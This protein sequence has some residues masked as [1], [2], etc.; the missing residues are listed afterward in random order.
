MNCKER[1]GS[2]KIRELLRENGRVRLRC[3]V[4]IQILVSMLCG[5]N[6]NTSINI[7]IISNIENCL[8]QAEYTSLHSGSLLVTFQYMTIVY[9]SE[10]IEFTALSDDR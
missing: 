5:S 6:I 7:A 2:I 10:K 3:L 1:V 9:P 4:Q 8:E